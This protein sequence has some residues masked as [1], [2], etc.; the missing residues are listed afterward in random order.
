MLDPRL[1]YIMRGGQHPNPKIEEIERVFEEMAVSSFFNSILFQKKGLKWTYN[2]MYYSH[3]YSSRDP[4]I[5]KFVYEN[6]PIPDFIEVETSTLCN[7]KCT[8]CEHSYWCEKNQNMSYEQFLHILNQFPRL[9]WIGLT[10]IGESY[11]NPDFD[12]MLTE[13]KRRGLY[14]ENFD[15]FT[16]LNEEHARKLV[17]LKVDKLYVSLDAATKETYEKIRVGA[18]WEEV[19]NNIKTLDRIKKEMNSYEPEF[20]FHFIV[21]KDNKHEMIKYLEMINGLGIDCRQVQFTILLHAYKEIAD[22]F[23]DVSPEEKEEIIKKGEELGLNVSFNMNT[24]DKT[25]LCPRSNCTLWMMPFIFVDGT[26]ISCCSMNE[27]NDRAWQKK[28]SLGNIFQQNFRDIWYG[29]KYKNLCKCNSENK[30]SEH[31]ERC[32]L[33]R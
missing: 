28:V 7:L 33:F 11:L 14:I 31:C 20:W 6:R 26:V 25:S 17:E 27:Q 22:K 9:K 5:V 1:T 21:S 13:C 19:I 29:E 30:I 24:Q 16:L 3:I 2:W 18:K 8:M 12:R 32:F 4:Q 10:G 15:N 23:I